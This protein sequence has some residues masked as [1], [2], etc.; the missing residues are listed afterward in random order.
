[1]ASPR[2][3]GAALALGAVNAL[4]FLGFE[5]LVHHGTDALWVDLAGTDAA[6]WRVVPLAIAGSLVL[7]LAVRMAGQRRL[8]PVTTDPLHAHGE[9]E[10]TTLGTIAATLAVGAVS[11]IAGGALGPEAPLVAASMALGALFA[12]G[13][14][15]VLASVGA[16]L[17]AFFGSLLMIVVPLLMLYRQKQRP[18]AADALPPVLAGV[19][20]YATPWVVRGRG[21]GYGKLP[22]GTGFD[23]GDFALAFALGACAVLLA[24]AVPRGAKRFAGLARDVDTRWPWPATAALFG[25]G[26]GLLYL[27]GGETVQFSGSSGSATLLRDHTDDGAPALAGLAAVKLLAAGWSLACGYR[28]GP[29]FPAVYA[30]VAVSLALGD[31]AGPGATIGAVGGIL[32]AMT[33]PAVGAIMLLALLP[34]K[35]A[36]IGLAGAAGAAVARRLITPP[37]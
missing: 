10:T 4:V 35:L 5:W 21:E 24:A 27:I 3:L 20:A 17:V 30:G 28:G 25:A 2:L 12:S 26:L 1:V 18:A 36:G 7:S 19:A 29:V 8:V 14:L 16:V 15:L 22:T 6:R 34:L 37:G 32:T 9:D 13:R 31:L 33:S 11:L 23:A